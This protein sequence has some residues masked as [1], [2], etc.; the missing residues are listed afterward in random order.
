M[1]FIKTLEKELA[2]SINEIIEHPF[3]NR[4]ADGWLNEKQLKYFAKEYY[5]YCF[6]F[7][8]IL[9]ACAANIPDDETRMPII[10]N[11]WEEHGEGDLSKS[12]RTLYVKFASALGL[13]IEEL[14]LS[15]TLPTT[16][17]CVDNLLSLCQHGHFL[18][19][20]GALGPGTEYFTNT[21]YAKIEAGLKKYDFLSAE[22]YNFWTV[23]ISLDEHHYS[24]MVTPIE[25]W[26][27]DKNDE[28]MVRSGAK[29]AIELEKLFWDGLEDNLPGK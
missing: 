1:S 11:L 9:S 17:I 8:K 5:V 14:E 29:K 16:R 7:P 3:V 28:D 18:E 26:I 24:D 4:I 13:T 21:E 20:L 25:K 10:E 12:H 2:V 23:H 27:K 22:D 6:E 15:E 19:S